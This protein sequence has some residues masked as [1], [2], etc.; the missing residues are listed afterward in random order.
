V[1]HGKVR[2]TVLVLCITT[3]SS[4][5]LMTTGRRNQVRPL[6]RLLDVPE[7]NGSTGG[8]LYVRLIIIIIIIIIIITAA[9]TTTIGYM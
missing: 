8:Q 5:N 7:R 6:K 4:K 9:T 3:E 2:M 1:Y